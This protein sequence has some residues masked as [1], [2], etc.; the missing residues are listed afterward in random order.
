MFA[1]GKCLAI[2][3]SWSR[4]TKWAKCTFAFF[5]RVV[6]MSRKRMKDL[7]PRACVVVRTSKMKT[8]PRRLADYVKRLHQKACRTCSTIIFLHSTNQIIDLWRCQLLPL[9]KNLSYLVVVIFFLKLHR[10]LQFHSFHFAGA[11]VL[12]LTGL[13]QLIRE[14][15]NL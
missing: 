4:C 9:R 7:L 11:V 10:F 14:H 12:P 8:S 13:P 6:F 1:L 3:P 2:I 15:P 5:A